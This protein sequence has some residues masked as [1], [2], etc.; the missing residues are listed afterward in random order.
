MQKVGAPAVGSDA[1]VECV[2]MAG[3]ADRGMHGQ[4]PGSTASRHI[5]TFST[6]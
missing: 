5:H 2:T 4:S 3:T 1:A 6:C